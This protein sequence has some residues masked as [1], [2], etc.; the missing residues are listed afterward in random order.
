M[1]IGRVEDAEVLG[2]V[3]RPERQR[4]DSAIAAILSRWSNALPRFEH[5]GDEDGAICL[6]S[7]FGGAGGTGRRRVRPCR[8]C[9]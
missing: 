9:P 1:V 5:D 2:E 3:V 7:T 6:C 8:G 4:V